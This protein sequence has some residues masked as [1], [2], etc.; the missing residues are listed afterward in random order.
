M[1]VLDKTSTVQTT[2]QAM[3]LGFMYVDCSTT[4]ILFGL[5]L[6]SS[7]F[8][9]TGFHIDPSNPIQPIPWKEAITTDLHSPERTQTSNTSQAEG[10]GVDIKRTA[11]ISKRSSELVECLVQLEQIAPELAAHLVEHVMRS[12]KRIA[13][14]LV[15][16]LAFLKDEIKKSHAFDCTKAQKKDVVT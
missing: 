9:S 11:D 10:K 2:L 14:P 15:N 4:T 8:S 7:A 13:I 3:E 5:I 16:K 6:L 12:V 1:S